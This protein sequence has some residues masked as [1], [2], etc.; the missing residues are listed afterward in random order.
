M[1]DQTD[2]VMSAQQLTR[3]LTGYRLSQGIHVAATLGIADLLAGGPRTSDDLAASTHTHAPSLYRFLL[4]ALA[5]E[6]IFEELP[7][8]RFGNNGASEMLRADA[9]VSLYGWAVLIGRPYFWQGWGNLLHSVQTG[10]SG[11]RKVTGVDSWRY[12]E[13]HPEEGAVFDRAM[14]EATRALSGAIVEAYDFGRF[15]RIADIAGGHGA[16]LAAILARYPSTTGVLFDQPHV[17]TGSAEVMQNAGV[18]DRC[19][20]VAG[21]FFETAPSADAYVLKHILHDWDDTD[22]VRILRTIRSVAPEDAL[23]LV[24]ERIVGSANEDPDSKL[25]DLNMLVGPGGQERTRQEFAELLAA[26]G[27]RFIDAHDAGPRHIIEAVWS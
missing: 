15:K 25:S 20:V 16:Q 7:D 13:Q 6:G 23:L 1:S 14:T 22:C 10:E 4:R 21:S 9:P 19:E 26:G 2:A 27:W 5:S 18:A 24:I 12:R 8:R 11:V 17:V 3:L